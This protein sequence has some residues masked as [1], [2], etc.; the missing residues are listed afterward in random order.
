MQGETLRV[1]VAPGEDL[2]PC[3][4]LADEGVVG[5]R[6]AVGGDADDLAGIDGK[7]LGLV[8]R[9]EAVADADE[10]GPVAGEGQA[11]A[12]V[13]GRAADLFGV[14]DGGDVVQRIAVELAARDGDV[15]SA[16]AALELAQIDAVIARK[17]RLERR[18]HQAGLA[19]G[20][21]GRNA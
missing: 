9:I 21:D 1:A 7:V 13:G 19:T 17:R 14:E 20:D 18:V 8:A 6:P 5:R 15:V 3:A 10:Q 2:G 11:R 16:E 4:R 12:D